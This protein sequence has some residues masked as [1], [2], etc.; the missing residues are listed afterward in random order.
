MRLD[1]PARLAVVDA[2]GLVG[3]PR[4]ERFDRVGR[5]ARRLLRT[6]VALLNVLTADQLWVV[7][8][9]AAEP[10]ALV[11]IPAQDALCTVTVQRGEPLVVPDAQADPRFAGLPAVRAAGG[12]RSYLG[13]PLRA[14]TGHVVGTLCVMD[15]VPRDW[16]AEQ[17]RSL[18]DLARWAEAEL[19]HNEVLSR[20]DEGERLRR[21]YASVLDHAGQGIVGVDRDGTVLLA[22]VAALRLTGWQAAGLVGRD[23][24]ETLH[25]VG[26]DGQPCSVRSCTVAR[27]VRS[28]QAL[29]SRAEVLWRRDGTTMPVQISCAPVHSAGRLSG[30][31]LVFDDVTEQRAVDRMKDEFV[32]VVSH[33]LRTP[34]TSLRGSLGLL[35]SG[36]VGNL[37]DEGQ[38]MAEIAVAS[39]DRL[40][41]LVDDI[42]D[43][44]RLVAGHVVLLRRAVPL[45]ELMTTAVQ[46]VA[47]F[48]EQAGV[49]VEVQAEDAVAWLDADRV[50]QAL[51]NLIG[52]AVK[53]SA[54][55]SVVTCTAALADP[56][57]LVLAVTDRGRGIPADQLER[58]FE[59]FAQVDSSD[60]RTHG[61]SGLGLAIT[62]S[63][64]EGHGGTIT[65]TSTVG[66]GTSFTVILPQRAAQGQARPAGR[67]AEDPP[68]RR[69][70]D[71]RA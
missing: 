69:R 65:A 44:E 58:V 16:T 23:L 49:L 13:H 60:S 52:N 19:A 18:A 31:V 30:A 14:A 34:L 63:V 67:R 9:G 38:S 10:G 47:G 29:L 61:G 45:P 54:A 39:C 51:V 6:P 37:S 70:G 43:L 17:T 1:D 12:V 27:S 33:E 59:R 24:H 71:R 5:T 62:R 22:N 26:V 25:P 36:L 48:A 53:F 42:L 21:E 46:A 56:R 32:S 8:D 2:V 35:A 50:V 7:G 20:L 3:A 41:R 66:V 11:T 57:R 40:V 28:G 4:E 68:S 15:V 55:G 64:V